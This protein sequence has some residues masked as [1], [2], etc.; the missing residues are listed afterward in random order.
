MNRSSLRSVFVAFALVVAT[1]GLAATTTAKPTFT[2]KPLK[3][4]AAPIHA[5]KALSTRLAQSDES[6]LKLT[7]SK[8]TRLMVKF[9]YDAAASYIGGVAGLAA[10]SPQVTGRSLAENR[11][12]VD[13]YERH[14]AG[15][16]KS[17]LAAIKAKVP[18]VEVLD[19]FR[20]AYGGA[21]MQ[22]PANKIKSLLSVPGVVAVQRNNLEKV[23]TDVT[24]AFLGADQVWPSLGGQKHAGEGVIVGVLDTGV[25]PE[26]PSY[27]D[28]GISHPGGTFACEF[29]D[30]TDPL[31]GDPFSCN[32]KLIG[33]YA[34]TDTYMFFIGAADGEFCNN[35][36]GECSTRDAD[37]HGTHTSTTAAGSRVNNASIFGINHGTISG[38]APGAH[39][40]GYRVCLELGCFGSDSVAAVEQ[41]I[42]D[43]VDVINFSISGGVD[44]YSDAVELAFLDAYAA[45]ILVNASAGNEGPGAATAN[46]A[47]P[48]VNTVGASTSN[49]H[50]NTKLVLNAGGDS[51]KFAGTTIT[52]GVSGSPVIQAGDVAGY[53]DQLCA[54]PLPPGSVTGMVVVCERGVVG[55]VQKSF[56]VLEGGGKG[57]ILYNPVLLSLFTDNFFLPTVML[58]GPQPATDMLDFLGAHPDATATWKTGKA[59][60]V[61]GDVMTA[62]SSRGPLGDWIKPDVT[63]PGIQILAGNS[64][65]HI[66]VAGG[67]A[68]ELFQVIAGTSMS[69]PHAAG[70]AALVKAAHPSWSPG[71]IKSA[72]MTSSVQDVLKED[73][74]TP[75]DP[76]DAGAGAIRANRAVAPTL[77][78]NES[79]ADYM[80]A[81]GGPFGRIGLNLPSIYAPVMPGLITTTRTAKNVSG[82]KQVFKAHVDEPAGANITV[83]PS[84]FALAKNGSKELT[85]MINGEGLADGQYF[86]QITLDPK[87]AGYNRVVLPVAFF[88]TQGDVSLTH[89]C[90]DTSIPEGGATGC[91]V[92]ATNLAP[93]AA[94]IHLSVKGPANRNL[95]IDNVSAPGLPSD[96]GFT[97][98]G[99]LAAAVA[100]TVDS[101]TP[102]GSPAGYLP[103][104]DF[105]VPPLGGF[106][107]ETIVNLGV[108]EF[109]FG[110]EA[111]TEIGLVS[112]GYA[113]VGGGDSSDVNFV[114]QSLPDP[115]VPNNVLAAF[116]TDLNPGAGGDLYA[117]ELTDG[118][119][120]W[121]VLELAAVPDFS[122]GLPYSFQI[123]I[124]EGATESITYAYGT[125]S[126]SGDPIGLTVGAEN[127]DGSSGVQLGAAPVSG[128]DF[129]I[130]TS[131]PA[132]GGGVVVTYDAL[133]VQSGDYKL[134]GRLTSDITPGTTSVVVTIEVT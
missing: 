127:R 108:P 86:G 124:Q 38:M 85:I 37:G 23:L 90:D 52:P 103:L 17:I 31:L 128:N 63:A 25:W 5:S 27:K 55:R 7:G 45:G 97:F 18:Q 43:G 78:F 12:A 14:V 54:D 61:R 131:P 4:T 39:I 53:N 35:T 126:G 74:E 57:M 50:F 42:L 93:V 15:L 109:L 101:I 111:Y 89:T 11:A 81:A 3:V 91:E 70:V 130:N 36:T 106:D 83:S 82:A 20:I 121:V 100:P 58:E 105:G 49:R 65:E 59:T 19:T 69:S 13:A 64:P 132:P 114:P 113:V 116:W 16:E 33:A 47:G 44:P 77:V 40:I 95:E 8:M 73:G 102:G 51:M 107:D 41:A 24:P 122:L 71:Q 48:W 120:V 92:T 80:T 62:F 29:G 1:V 99:I 75:F 26:H 72:L 10:T 84:T 28:K 117:A 110:G 87:A 32:D 115:A 34:F 98:D 104:A 22:V 6:L 123:W 21:A 30:G 134:R 79:A 96:N 133:G 129:S 56:N 112:N 9:D 119:N 60:D 118:V 88:K 2:A 94:D 76:F 67:P 46:H 66:G 68:G 125:L